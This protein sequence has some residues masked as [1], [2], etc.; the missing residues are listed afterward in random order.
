[1]RYSSHAQL[2]IELAHQEASRLNHEHISTGHLLLGLIREGEGSVLSFL[3]GMKVDLEKMKVE[4][5][6]SMEIRGHG[7]VIGP[8]KLTTRASNAMQLA[9]EESQKMGHKYVGTEHIL[10]GI[11]LEQDGIAPKILERAGVGIDRVRAFAMSV[12]VDEDESFETLT[13]DNAKMMIPAGDPYSSY[14]GND[15]EVLDLKGAYQLLKITKDEI[16]RLLREDDVPGRMIGGE[17]RFSRNA[18]IKWLGEGK[19]RDYIDE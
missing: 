18:L 1:M 4:V 13:F 9:D 8:L 17:W 6:N 12:N 10:I 19:S 15:D 3:R 16:N 14:S 2:T 7:T 5:E 11:I